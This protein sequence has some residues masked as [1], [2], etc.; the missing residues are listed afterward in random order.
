MC[1]DLAADVMAL[2]DEPRCAH[3]RKPWAVLADALDRL[4][5]QL[6]ILGEAIADPADA[7]AMD[8]V[9]ELSRHRAERSPTARRDP[10]PHSAHATL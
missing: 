2:L 8:N 5:M 4:C 6:Q 1:Q 9:I 3:A 7:A 10:G